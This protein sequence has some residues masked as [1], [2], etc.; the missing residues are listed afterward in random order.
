MLARRRWTARKQTGDGL[1]AEV[2]VTRE[3][4]AASDETESYEHAG[5]ALHAPALL[6]YELASALTGLLAAGLMQ[7][8]QLDEAWT[9]AAALP[10]TS[11]L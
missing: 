8:E 10:I 7:D 1:E 2:V 9:A 6:R 4:T 5:E 3:E 11:R